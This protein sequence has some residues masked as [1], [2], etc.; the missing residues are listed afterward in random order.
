M[1]P[2]ELQK[3]SPLLMKASAFSFIALE[4]PFS[5]SLF[6]LLCDDRYPFALLE[7]RGDD[8]STVDKTR[9]LAWS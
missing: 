5:Q 1:T 3:G 6:W 9:L 8:E 2:G 7:G 4:K